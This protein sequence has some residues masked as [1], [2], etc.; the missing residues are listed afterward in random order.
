MVFHNI[1]GCI[2]VW[3]IIFNALDTMLYLLANK[4][5]PANFGEILNLS[6]VPLKLI[7]VQEHF[8]KPVLFPYYTMWDLICAQ[9][10]YSLFSRV[11]YEEK[12]TSYSVNWR[13]SIC[14]LVN[15]ILKLCS[16]WLSVV[17]KRQFPSTGVPLLADIF[18]RE[19]LNQFHEWFT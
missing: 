17:F 11:H 14:L 8:P 18:R 4:H 15:H 3:V 6:L 10:K 7:H 9:R 1:F 13:L 19:L 16:T 12:R 2:Y 5:R